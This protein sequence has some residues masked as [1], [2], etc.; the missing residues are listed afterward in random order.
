MAG[1]TVRINKAKLLE[2][3]RECPGRARQVIQKIAQ[4]V[5][6]EIKQSFSAQSPSSPGN[7][8]GVDTGTLKNSII[9][10]PGDNA[11]EWVVHDGVEYGVYLEYGTSKMAARP[12]FL[13]AVE[14][15]AQTIPDSLLESVVK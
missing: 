9:A 11:D 12:F 6:Q 7:P 1:I 8:P 15:V 4:D 14:K 10:E 5:E 13:P 2:L 3:E